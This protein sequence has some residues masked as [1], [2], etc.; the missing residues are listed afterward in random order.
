MLRLVLLTLLAAATAEVIHEG[1]C[2]E[3]KPVNNFN[4][5]AYQGIWYEISKF[6]NESEKNGKCSSAE[7]KLEGDVVKVKNVHIID[8][9]KKYIEG[10]AKLTDDANKAAKLTVTF[11]FGEISRDGSVQV[12]ATDYNNYAIAYNC[13]YD[14]K[15]KS[16]QVFVWILSRNKKLE[17]DA[18]TAVDNFIKEHSKEIDS[19]KLVHTDFSE[20]ACKFTISSVITEHGKH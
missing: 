1:T 15:K 16:H 8:G 19:S 5:T 14:D 18:K 4:L 20:E 11:K 12:L 17:G 13:K 7:Y 10:T 2:P 3:L 9:V 6:P